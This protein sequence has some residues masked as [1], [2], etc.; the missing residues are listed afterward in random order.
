MPNSN[1]GSG[2]G[3]A[4][5]IG[6]CIVVSAVITLVTGTTAHWVFVGAGILMG[7]YAASFIK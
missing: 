3:I 2:A 5:I 6:G 7:L 1:S 4:A